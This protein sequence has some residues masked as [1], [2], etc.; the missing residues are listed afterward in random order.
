MDVSGVNTDRFPAR[1]HRR[2]ASCPA[3][4]GA[5]TRVSGQFNEQ[6]G[7]DVP[8]FWRQGA[9]PLR[10]RQAQQGIAGLGRA[11]AS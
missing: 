9:E 10:H 11:G 5:L 4:V 8:R 7:E 2:L 1:S 6:I 3:L